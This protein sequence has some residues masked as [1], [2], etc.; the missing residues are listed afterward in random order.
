VID[1]LPL[2]LQ[3]QFKVAEMDIPDDATAARYN[4]SYEKMVEYVGRLHRAG[5][6]VLPGT[7]AIPGF[8]LQRELEL[9]VQAGMTPSEAL[10]SAT[11]VAAKIARVDADRG[12]IAPGLL[13]DMLLVE[14][15][16]TQDIGAL[17]HVALVLTQGRVVDPS[18]V[19]RELG[20]RPF[21]VEA[22]AN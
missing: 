18:K 5:V 12:R 1:H 4:T 10:Q 22:T 19:Y 14:G 13:A 3:R 20:I 15:D 16:P 9:Y 17:R 21:V 2:S 6:T 7:D 8:T 11:S